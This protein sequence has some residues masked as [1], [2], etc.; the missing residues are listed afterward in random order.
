MWSIVIALFSYVR[1]GVAAPEFL[2]AHKNVSN[3]ARCFCQAHKRERRKLTIKLEFR[4][5]RNYMQ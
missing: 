5:L 1:C 2:S 3:Q 4:Y